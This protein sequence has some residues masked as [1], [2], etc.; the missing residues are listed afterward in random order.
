[1]IYTEENFA[2]ASFAAKEQGRYAINGVHVT[3][4]YTQAT[5]GKSFIRM[6]AIE[7]DS[8][9]DFL[10]NRAGERSQEFSPFLLPA[11]QAQ[12]IA[13]DLRRSIRRDKN[14]F[15]SAWITGNKRPRVNLLVDGSD[16]QRSPR[17]FEQKFPAVDM[18]LFKDGIAVTFASSL[19]AQYFGFLAKHCEPIVEMRFNGHG[20]MGISAVSRRGHKIDG[21]IMNC[22]PYDDTRTVE[23]EAVK[24]LRE[25]GWTCEKK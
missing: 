12:C 23:S 4:K 2:I 21:V 1:M 14:A 24:F 19:L 5:N 13:N 7:G 15:S 9:N 8:Y 17:E 6:S 3:P 22:K 11:A 25:R 18:I 16:V 20:Q 10:D